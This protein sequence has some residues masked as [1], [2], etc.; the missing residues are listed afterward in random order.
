MSQP[1][2]GDVHVNTPLT[3]ISIMYMQ[4]ADGFV[5]DQVFPNI[6]VSKKSDLYYLYDRGFFNRAEME[7]R[8]PGTES[9]GIGYELATATYNADVWAIHHDIPDQ[10]RANADSVLSLDRET[11]NLLSLQAML[12]REK[13]WV[14]NYFT[15]SLWTTDIEGVASGPT[16]TQVLQWNDAT[17][18]PIENIR[19]QKTTV[20]QSTGYLPN[21]LVLGWQVLDALLEHPDIID[22]I[23]YGQTPGA[24]AVADLA[25]LAKVLGVDRILPMKAI[26]NTANEG[27]TNVHAFIGGK[28]ALL[29]YSAP[30]P[31]V[32]LPSGGYTFSWT[33]AV[34]NGGMGQRIK[35]FRIET[36]EADRVEIQMAFD[37]KLVSA[38]L[39]VLF[40]TIVA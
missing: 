29:C 1:T 9:A 31:G 21:T 36:R 26:E 5:A 33:G 27:A 8:A 13:Q 11:T 39:G 10:I 20:L 6:P 34:G 22:R 37:Q 25:A 7:K 18:T 19:A 28:L 23:K 32:M 17:S 40:Y 38:D 35:K 14:A 3:N 30:T 12:R 4:Q 16:G 15:T 2:L 24:P